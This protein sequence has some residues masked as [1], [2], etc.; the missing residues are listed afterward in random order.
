MGINKFIKN[1]KNFLE[2]DDFSESKKK[3]A[4]KKLLEKLAKRQK[5]TK[6]RL[7]GDLSKKEKRKAE[8]ELEIIKYQIKKGKKLLSKLEK[9]QENS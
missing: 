2:L 9:S 8:E 1:V 5:A 3:K 7:D 6:K 4:I